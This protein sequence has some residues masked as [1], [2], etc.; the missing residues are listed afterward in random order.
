MKQSL[1]RIVY[2]TIEFVMRRQTSIIVVASLA[3][4]ISIGLLL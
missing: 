2:L 3:T 4:G 1:A